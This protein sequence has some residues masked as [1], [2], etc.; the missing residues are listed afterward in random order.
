MLAYLKRIRL[1]SSHATNVRD[2]TGVDEGLFLRQSI[3][4]NMFHM[5]HY[6]PISHTDSCDTSRF[7]VAFSHND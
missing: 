6:Q 3:D 5:M 1:Q 7:I 2:R 4:W